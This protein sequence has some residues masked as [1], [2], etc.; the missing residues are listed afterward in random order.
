ML[1]QMSRKKLVWISVLLVLVIGCLTLLLFRGP[2]ICAA[3]TALAKP[4]G[5][6]LVAERGKLGFGT[7]EVIGIQ[8]NLIGVPGV[9]VSISQARLQLISIKS[10]PIELRGMTIDVVGSP[11]TIIDDAERWARDHPA[12]VAFA[13]AATDVSIYWRNTEPDRPW[14]TI[15]KATVTPNQSGFSAAVETAGLFGVSVGPMAATWTPEHITAKLGLGDTDLS[16]ALASANYERASRKASIQLNSSSIGTLATIV[17]VSVPAGKNASIEGFAEFGLG[18]ESNTK[19]SG[20]L[21]AKLRG[22]VPPHPKELDGILFGDYTGFET[23]FVI[24][25]DPATLTLTESRIEAGSFV[26]TGAGTVTFQDTHANIAMRLSGNIPCS[27]LTRSVAMAH[28]GIPA[29]GLLG[30]IAATA[31]GG[32]VK[33]DMSLAADTRRLSAAQLN[34]N[35]SFGCKLRLP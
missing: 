4:R 13:F 26:L 24:S 14:L 20:R 18:P 28:L 27:L 1:L 8:A 9:T 34:Q 31:I 19:I 33:V 29:G 21:S 12:A 2:I 7:V 22:F 10:S 25:T 17:G 15:T 5:I 6:A 16:R 11:A 32:S 30:G 3:A 35:L 23:G